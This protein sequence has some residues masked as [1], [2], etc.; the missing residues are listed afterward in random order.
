MDASDSDHASSDVSAGTVPEPMQTLTGNLPSREAVMFRKAEELQAKGELSQA[1]VYFDEVLA[2]CP[3]CE[4]A[5]VHAQ[6]IRRML[7]EEH[8]MQQWPRKMVIEDEN[9]DVKQQSPQAIP[10]VSKVNFQVEYERC[11]IADPDDDTSL[12]EEVLVKAH[13]MLAAMGCDTP[14]I[15]LKDNNIREVSGCQ[16]DAHL[17]CFATMQATYFQPQLL[18]MST[19]PAFPVSTKVDF[20]VDHE[21]CWIADPDDDTSLDEEVLVKAHK[22]LAAMGCDTPLIHLMKNNIREVSGCQCDAHLRCF[23]TMQATYFQPQ[24]LAMS[25]N[26]AFPVS[27]KVDFI[28]D[29]ETCWIADPDDDLSLDE[30]VLVKAHKMLA[31]LG[32]DTPLI[33]LMKNDIRQVSGCQCD[34]HLKCLATVQVTYFQPQLLAMSKNGVSPVSAGA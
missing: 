23:A 17:R 1:L 34:A 21:T 2:T 5:V 33:H 24:L 3:S 12:D 16:C 10:V 31:A 9:E 8:V 6:L 29:H 4:Q 22:M 28:V 15:H 30:E 20:I 32:C 19:N 7:R 14:L 11:W 13:K 18:A 26:P 25:T 27:T